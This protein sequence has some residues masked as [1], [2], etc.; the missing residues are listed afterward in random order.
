M[1]PT[2]LLRAVR[3]RGSHGEALEAFQV[4]QKGLAR[5]RD[6]RKLSQQ[7]QPDAAGRQRVGVACSGGQAGEQG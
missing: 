5:I 4:G 3:G 7:R 6:P 1:E 2:H